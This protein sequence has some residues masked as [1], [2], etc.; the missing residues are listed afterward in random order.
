[1]D[2]IVGAFKNAE[3]L[4]RKGGALLVDHRNFLPA[5]LNGKMNRN[6]FSPCIHVSNNKRKPFVQKK[7][8]LYYS[9]NWATLAPKISFVIVIFLKNYR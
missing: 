3:K 8:T 1:M 4:L 5:I 7:K 9:G 2:V 6:G